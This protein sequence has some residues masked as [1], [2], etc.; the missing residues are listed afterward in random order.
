MTTKLNAREQLEA[1]ANW[2]GYHDED[3]SFALKTPEDGLKLWAYGQ[4][5]P[6]LAEMCDETEGNAADWT[7][8]HFQAAIGYTPFSNAAEAFDA[9]DALH[10]GCGRL[11]ESGFDREE[12]GY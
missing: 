12:V 8:A 10:S 3:L 9:L 5:H 4:A 2:L 1:A 7:D 11:T 6:E